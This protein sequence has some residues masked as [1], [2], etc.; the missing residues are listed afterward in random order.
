MMINT[1]KIYRLP[2]SA[3][4]SCDVRSMAVCAALEDSEV[5]ALERIMIAKSLG[6]NEILVEEGEER[7]F[8]Y[9]LTSGM[10]R[11][12]STLADGRRQISGFLLPGDYLGL[13]DDHTYSRTAEAVGD[14][15]LCAFPVREMDRL[16]DIYPRLGER[17]HAMT[18]SALRAAQDSQFLLARLAPTERLAS[19]LLLLSRRA[20]EHRQPPNPVLLPMTRNDIADYLGL[21]VETVSR[22]FTKL[23]S[24]G[25]IALPQPHIAEIRDRAKLAALAGLPA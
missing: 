24:E 6:P 15:R 25:L 14:S 20:E 5:G 18:R 13:A 9:T 7:R 17:L 16:I 3:C 10:L 21:T 2:C 8:V 22:S 23:K 19:F 11:L 12:T 4:L 1:A